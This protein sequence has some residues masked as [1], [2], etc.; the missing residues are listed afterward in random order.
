MRTRMPVLFAVVL[1]L[2]VGMGLCANMARYPSSTSRARLRIDTDGDA[3]RDTT[4]FPVGF[5][6]G[7][8]WSQGGMLDTLIYTE[9]NCLL[10]WGH[11]LYSDWEAYDLDVF[12]ENDIRVMMWPYDHHR[13]LLY[14]YYYYDTLTCN[15][16]YDP[17]GFR[18]FFS[19]TALDMVNNNLAYPRNVIAWYLDDEPD[20]KR[21]HTDSCGSYKFNP[22]SLIAFYDIVSDEDET[23]DVCLAIPENIEDFSCCCDLVMNDEYDFR[24]CCGYNKYWSAGLQARRSYDYADARDKPFISILQG[25]GPCFSIGRWSIDTCQTDLCQYIK[26]DRRQPPGYEDSTQTFIGYWPEYHDLRNETYSAL[27]QGARGVFYWGL[28]HLFCSDPDTSVLTMVKYLSRE[29][30]CGEPENNL[31]AISDVLMYWDPLVCVSSNF[32]DIDACECDIPPSATNIDDL[33]YYVA[34]DP[35]DPNRCLL[36]AVNDCCGA[37]PGVRFDFDLN[38]NTARVVPG[39][40]PHGYVEDTL[41][42]LG[43]DYIEDDFDP[44]A[45]HVYV[46]E[47]DRELATLTIHANYI[48]Y[49]YPQ[50]HGQPTQNEAPV[51][52]GGIDFTTPVQRL[53]VVGDTV[54]V[55]ARAWAELYRES[56]YF[57]H[58]PYHSWSD[59]GA[60]SHDVVVAGDMT[61]TVY[62]NPDIINTRACGWPEGLF[63]AMQ[64]WAEAGDTV[65][66]F[67]T[68]SWAG[69]EIAMTRPVS[70]ISE[71]PGTGRIQ[72]FGPYVPLRYRDADGFTIGLDGFGLEFITKDESYACLDLARCDD[73]TIEGNLFEGLGYG[74][75]Q[76]DYCIGT[77]SCWGLT[78][79]ANQFTEGRW[80]L[81]SEGDGDITVVANDF[82]GSGTKTLNNGVGIGHCL[83]IGIYGNHF[84]TEERG[85]SM[86]IC[87]DIRIGGTLDSGNVFTCPSPLYCPNIFPSGMRVDAECNYWGAMSWDDIKTKITGDDSDLI[88]FVP[89]ADSSLS[90]RFVPFD[91]ALT[92]AELAAD[93]SLCPQGDLHELLVTLTVRDEEDGPIEGMWTEGTLVMWL[94]INGN[95]LY[96]CYG[97]LLFETERTDDSGQVIVDWTHMGGCGAVHVA[98]IEGVNLGVPGIGFVTSPDINGDGVCNL[99]DFGMFAGMYG[100]SEHCGD[101]DFDGIVDLTDFGTFA[102]HYGHACSVG[103]LADVPIAGES[104]SGMPASSTVILSTGGSPPARYPREFELRIDDPAVLIEAVDAVISYKGTGARPV[105]WVSTGDVHFLRSEPLGGLT[106][107]PDR[108]RVVSSIDVAGLIG[109]ETGCVGALQF[110]LED[111]SVV[112]QAELESVSGITADGEII[113]LDARLV[114]RGS[115]IDEIGGEI[116]VATVLELGLNP[117]PE[118]ASVRF[119]AP[120]REGGHLALDLYDVTGRHIGCLHDGPN[121]GKIHTSVIGVGGTLGMVQAPGLY[122]VRLSVD[123]RPLDTQKVVVLK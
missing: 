43:Q 122:F 25:H 82:T 64:D 24:N 91:P 95:K 107:Q 74:T 59:G 48:G 19:G 21:W 23:R 100:T 9:I 57:G 55:A 73:V 4:F 45:V 41:F 117:A 66:V 26:P 65:Q 49:N 53:V 16:H 37:L 112:L 28:G 32:D 114:S 12:A 54:T 70:L 99:I 72:Y 118:G 108:V 105:G 3:V 33:N 11:R 67:G 47:L 76:E 62:Y 89:W 110:T 119:G 83:G 60:R 121:D 7:A 6:G 8:N 69:G 1:L 51:I 101:F 44:W 79:R 42:V 22:D 109:S 94:G 90:E 97:K 27:I 71:G 34:T 80:G 14:N 10:V 113:E 102:G 88:D 98:A 104:H 5:Y 81:S 78:V 46:L 123:G 29:M 50:G 61:L 35:A 86:S 85:L 40:Y 13:G 111:A 18:D 30:L 20:L 2:M 84:G 15:V 36:I 38:I 120:L 115:D 106:S 17:D 52:I 92:T 103:L 56:N 116:A 68:Y 39:K 75:E 93:T 58:G 63:D 31:P 87:Q 77:Y 96:P